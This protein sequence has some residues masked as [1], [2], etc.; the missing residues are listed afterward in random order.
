MN[1]KP[2]N[3]ESEKL[4]TMISEANNIVTSTVATIE[5]DIRSAL[6]MPIVFPEQK[7]FLKKQEEMFG[8]ISDIFNIG[9]EKST[10]NELIKDIIKSEEKSTL[11]LSIPYDMKFKSEINSV[12]LALGNAFIKVCKAIKM[13]ELSESELTSVKGKNMLKEAFKEQIKK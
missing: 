3:S 8:K 1:N 6:F 13:G 5:E 11:I 9:I 12:T 2:H 7:V 4:N 10:L